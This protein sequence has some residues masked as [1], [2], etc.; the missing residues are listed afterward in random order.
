MH[1]QGFFVSEI[2]AVIKILKKKL[3]AVE[4][5]GVY[6]HFASAKNPAFPFETLRQMGEFKKAIALLEAAGFR[7]LI[8]HAAATAGTI[9]FPQSHFDMV[10]I[11]IGL[12]GLW[13]SKETQAA[14]EREFQLKSV[15][16]WKTIVGQIKKLPKNSRIGYDLTEDFAHRLLARLSAPA[17]KCRQSA[18]KRQR[19]ESSRPGFNG[20]DKR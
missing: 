9:I 13:P 19:G 12:Y 2:P 4:I 7:R 11:G 6:T 16:S 1:R 20:Y 8:K 14:F 10:R 17:F 5:E 18:N 3:P 15:L